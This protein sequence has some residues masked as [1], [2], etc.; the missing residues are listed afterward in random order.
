MV[1]VLSNQKIYWLKT[2]ILL[3]YVDF[4]IRL[5]VKDDIEHRTGNSI[6]LW[7]FWFLCR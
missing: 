5:L 3:D 6:P 7:F 4:N 1:F 2:T